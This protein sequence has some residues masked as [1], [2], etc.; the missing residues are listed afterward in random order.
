MQAL[1][2]RVDGILRRVK[3][4]SGVN[5]KYE[6]ELEYWKNELRRLEAWFVDGTTDWWGL[7]PPTPEQKVNI[8]DLWV[9][10]AVMTTTTLRPTY[11]ERLGLERDSFAGKRVLEIGC[12]PMAPILQFTNCERHGVDPLVNLYMAAGWPLFDYD[13]K[14]VNTGGESLPYPDGYFDA[15]IAV[16]ALDHVDDFEQVASEMQRVLRAGGE[17]QFEVEYHMPTVTEPV[18]LSDSRVVKA[19]SECDLKMIMSRSGHELFQ[20]LVKRFNL[21]P[22][23]FHHNSERFCAWRAVRK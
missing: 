17:A 15:V 1:K 19:F 13:A 4:P 9:S 23:E 16:N 7:A 6:T 12:G 8:S 21:Q 22:F 5:R 20:A 2:E 11:T 3:P 10:N 14:F 18:K